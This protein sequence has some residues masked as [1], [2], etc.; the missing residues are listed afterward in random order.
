MRH[1]MRSTLAVLLA[2]TV[3]W[4][5]P[6]AARA[7]LSPETVRQ[8]ERLISAE[9]S[10]QHIPALSVAV[11][12]DGEVRWTSGFGIADLENFVPATAET[13]Y[14]VASVAKPLT[15]A[16][17]LQLVERGTM[18]MDAPVRTYVPAFPEK[19]WPITIRQLL[20]HQS[21]IRHYK[22]DEVA[23]TRYYPT[24]L[25]ALDIF[26]D[27]P[28]LFQ[29]GTRSAYS[30]YGYTLLGAAIEGATGLT[31]ID[32]LRAN[33][34]RPA[35]MDHTTIDAVAAII[36]N[37]ARGYGKLTDGTPRN[38]SLAD[39]SYKIPAGGLCSTATDL[40]RFAIALDTGALLKP[41]TVEQMWTVHPPQAGDGSTSQ[42]GQQATA[43]PRPLN[44]GYGWVIGARNGEKEV[45][46]TGGQQGTSTVLVVRPAS[47]VAV[48]IMANMESVRVSDL[49]RGIADVVSRK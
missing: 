26:K 43:E 2:L 10:R 3:W 28:L 24:L 4:V 22:G 44:Y 49:A 13:V 34:F 45:F 35:G 15:A 16:A 5:A 25:E 32:A 21:G 41:A 6:A 37:R 38:A 29:P 12:A 1:C 47:H 17:V 9:M 48:G 23:S 11:A 20:T 40:V 7:G 31:Y 36:P 39:T 18:Q 14:R 8:I 33:I 19:P 27:A 42:P 46:H 30:T